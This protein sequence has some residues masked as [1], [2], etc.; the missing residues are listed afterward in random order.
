MTTMSDP[1]GTGSVEVQAVATGQGPAKTAVLDTK[2]TSLESPAL[3]SVGLVLLGGAAELYLEV[4]PD[5]SLGRA[6]RAASSQFVR[7]VVAP[8]MGFAWAAACATEDEMAQRIRGWLQLN[9]VARVLADAEI[10]FALLHAIDGLPKNITTTLV[11]A[12]YR[13][14]H[15]ALEDARRLATALNAGIQ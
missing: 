12:E 3:L 13:S 8:Q 7:E 15:P 9:S 6:R 2:F 1:R 11:K 14:A 10:D 5:S 4:D